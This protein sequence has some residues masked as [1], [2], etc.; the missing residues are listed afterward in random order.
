ML[1]KKTSRSYTRL[2]R[3]FHAFAFTKS[4]R[5]AIGCLSAL[6]AL[7][8]FLRAYGL[9]KPAMEWAVTAP[10]QAEPK[11][12]QKTQPP[13]AENLGDTSP[14]NPRRTYTPPA[15]MVKKKALFDL[16]TADTFDLQEI[17]GIGTV[18]ARRIVN[19]RN[20]LGGFVDVG[21][22]REVWGIDSLLLE[23]ISPSVY[24]RQGIFRKI[25]LNSADIRLLKQHPYLDYYQAKE[26]Y[27]HRQKYG[28]FTSLLQVREVNLMDSGTFERI[29]PYLSLETDE[30]PVNSHISTNVPASK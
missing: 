7:T 4:D 18:Y 16:N 24:V 5:R 20:K 28:A 21:Q 3:F 14:G 30:E 27:L 26:I 15:Y 6:I 10:M 17:R 19:Y 1:N 11:P 29:L 13:K 9:V 8:V 22:L 2:L 25:P 23:K 12:W